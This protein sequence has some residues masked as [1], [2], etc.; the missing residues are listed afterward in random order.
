MICRTILM[1][2]DTTDGCEPLFDGIA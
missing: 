1:I 2:F